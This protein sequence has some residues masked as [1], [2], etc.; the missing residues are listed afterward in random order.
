[1]AKVICI[2]KSEAE[3]MALAKRIGERLKGPLCLTLDGDLG[4]GKTHFAQGLG[5]GLGVKEALTSP[6]FTLMNTYTSGRE[7][8]YHFDLYRIEEEEELDY[9]GFSEYAH[10]SISLIEWANKFPDS[11]PEDRVSIR[12]DI[13]GPEERK[14][15]FETELLSENELLE[16][17]GAYVSRH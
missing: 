8:L 5:Q 15:T 6:T 4:A 3:T 2:T 13:V 16:W 7:E 10:K 11:L 9:I 17:G 12:I 14:I 1:M